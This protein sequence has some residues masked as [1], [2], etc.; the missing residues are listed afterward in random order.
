[1]ESFLFLKIYLHLLNFSDALGNVPMQ[2]VYMNLLSTGPVWLFM[3][4][5]LVTALLPD[6]LVGVWETYETADGVLVSKVSFGFFL[7]HMEAS[8]F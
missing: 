2:F 5:V 1:M 3:P 6:I 8:R 4:L 7:S